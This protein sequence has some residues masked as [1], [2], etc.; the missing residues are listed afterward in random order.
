MRCDLD[1]LNQL[2]NMGVVQRWGHTAR[3]SAAV[4]I[5][6]R[7]ILQQGNSTEDYAAHSYSSLLPHKEGCNTVQSRVPP[8]SPSDLR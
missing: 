7:E 6:V 4:K 2:L 8:W 5:V 3:G 1:L